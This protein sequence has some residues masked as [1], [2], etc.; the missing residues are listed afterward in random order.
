LPAELDFA[1]TGHLIHI[2]AASLKSCQPVQAKP[3][4]FHIENRQF[5]H[6]SRESE[7]GLQIV[8]DF[9]RDLD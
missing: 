3:L 1:D 9:S 7:P 2:A 4:Q 8:A 6:D 5:R